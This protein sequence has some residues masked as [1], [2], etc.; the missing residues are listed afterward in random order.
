MTVELSDVPPVDQRARRDRL[1][2]RLAEHSLDA[3]VVTTAVNARYLTG[4]TGSNAA[5]VVTGDP[6]GD[7]LLTDG[8][9]ET[10]AA[11]QAPGID[12]VICRAETIDKV[13]ERLV[14][15]DAVRVGFEA[16]RLDWQ[17]A[18]RL[19]ETGGTA[20]LE[21]RP[22]AGH[23]ERLRASKDPVELEALRGACRLTDAAFEDLL[24]WLAAGMTE[25]EVAIRLERTMVELGAE[26]ASFP[27][28]VAAGEHSA[29]PHHRPGD[30][31]LA[32]G[33]LVK[34]D[35]GATWAGYHADMSRT[36]ALGQ[37]PAELRH[38]HE[39]VRAAQQAGVGAAAA[40]VTAG[41]VDA[42]SRTPIADAG[43]GERFVH[44]T[45]H[46]VGLE[47]HEWPTLRDGDDAT[48]GTGMTV[49]V[50]PGIYLPGRGGVRIED[51][52]AIRDAGPPEVLTTSPRS[53][54]TL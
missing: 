41:T 44:S 38:I 25:R 13:V 47:I 31:R 27:S 6:A 7:L 9:Y 14:A 16:D 1:R 40:G 15:S 50:E 43:Y 12:R 49:T 10:Q 54:L 4:F 39:V 23:V 11:E 32:G 34:F 26:E 5:V 42:A 33:E 22:A 30:R 46:G 2:Q 21:L 3:L 53:L 18:E 37:P 52:V 24:G 28:I 48:L 19:R 36:V 17:T 20:G 35:F 45:G 29:V 51:T 8:R